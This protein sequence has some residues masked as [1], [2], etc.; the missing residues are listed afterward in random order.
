MKSLA[1]LLSA[2]FLFLCTLSAYF[3]I[4]YYRVAH[5]NYLNASEPGLTKF[6]SL[7]CLGLLT[8]FWMLR[9]HW[10]DEFIAEKQ[11]EYLSAPAEEVLK[12]CR[13]TGVP[14]AVYLRS[15]TLETMQNTVKVGLFGLGVKYYKGSARRVEELLLRSVEKRIPVLALPNPAYPFSMPGVHRFRRPGM[16]WVDFLERIVKGASLV[17]IYYSDNSPGLRLEVRLLL[18]TRLADRTLL[19]IGK[20]VDAH[21]DRDL[22]ESLPQFRGVVFEGSD[23]FRE[24][25][26]DH[27]GRHLDSLPAHAAYEDMKSAQRPGREDK[28]KWI[29]YSFNSIEAL[30]VIATATFIYFLADYYG[31][32]D[33]SN[34][35]PVITVQ[36]IEKLNLNQRTIERPRGNFNE[37]ISAGRKALAASREVQVDLIQ[38][39]LLGPDVRHELADP[40]KQHVRFTYPN[41]SR[42]EVKK[43][44][45]RTLLGRLREAG[46]TKVEFKDEH[47]HSWVYDLQR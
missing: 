44:A 42:G 40:D 16:L 7:L 4:N 30:L 21:K 3:W 28:G 31:K 8:F 17:V 26:R 13:E 10:L 38:R 37:A 23:N 18:E 15:F 6:A 46:I 1:K 33:A 14:Y 29:R 5:T 36:P 24:S 27:V 11:L 32:H 20:N 9:R 45:T 34:V 35:A 39:E 19:I 2:S 12:E 25:L 22:R 47:G 41:L 43:I